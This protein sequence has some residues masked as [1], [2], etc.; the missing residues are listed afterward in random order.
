MAPATKSALGHVYILRIDVSSS[1]YAEFRGGELGNTNQNRV[2]VHSVQGLDLQ[3]E[4]TAMLTLVSCVLLLLLL[5]LAAESVL[6]FPR[7]KSL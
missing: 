3:A 1:N 7:K 6:G 5:L 2:R 4:R